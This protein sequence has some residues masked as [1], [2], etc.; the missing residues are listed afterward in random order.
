MKHLKSQSQNL[1]KIFERS[2]TVKEIAEPF[3]S[4]DI[5]HPADKVQRFMNEKDY[6]IVGV[7]ENAVIVGYINR[8]EIDGKNLKDCCVPFEQENTLPETTPLIDVF[9]VLGNSPRVF[10]TFLGR[11]DGII[12]RGDLQKIPVRIYLFGLISLIEMQLLRII[13]E[14]RPDDWWKH[15]ISRERLID[16]EKIHFDRKQ[17]NADIGLLECLQFA[18]KR[19]IVLKSDLIE[20]KSKNSCKKL[21]K[22]LEKLRNEV[23]HAQYIT[24]HGGWSNF[25]NLIEE[26]QEFLSNCETI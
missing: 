3:A 26:S 5:D 9:K 18:D 8:T 24:T 1:R 19:D 2:V 23:A 4:F 17:R 14:Y 21:L 16:A 12:T 25:V 10:V 22:D 13:K 20:F 11:V 6:D 7:M 15:L